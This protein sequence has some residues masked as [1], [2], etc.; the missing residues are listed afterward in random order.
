MIVISIIVIG[1]IIAGI[2]L[3][4]INLKNPLSPADILCHLVASR[5]L[6][7]LD[8]SQ[9]KTINYDKMW[10]DGSNIKVYFGSG[11]TEGGVYFKSLSYNEK[12]IYPSKASQKKLERAF[13][14]RRDLIDKKKSAEI[15]YE[16]EMTAISA[17][18]EL[19]GIA[20]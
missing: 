11:W 2:F 15:K 12:S 16:S 20:A 14:Q 19:M 10:L 18:E 13:Q 5:M 9:A 17:I 3:F 1:S 8:E 6:L 7:N 4:Y